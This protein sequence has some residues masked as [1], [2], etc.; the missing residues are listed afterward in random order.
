VHVQL[1]RC[2]MFKNWNIEVRSEW[3]VYSV[4]VGWRVVLR[5]SWSLRNDAIEAR[6]RCSPSPLVVVNRV[7]YGNLNV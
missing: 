4:H 3:T 1:E 2:L 6:I 5:E 7:K